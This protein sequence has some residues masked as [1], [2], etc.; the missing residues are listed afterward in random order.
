MPQTRISSR[1]HRRLR[2]LAE[3]TGETSEQILDRALDLLERRRILDGIN[4]GYAA[5]RADADKWAAEQRER[6][7]WDTTLS[8][9]E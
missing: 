2:T 7:P 3:E 5:L 6:A 1:A 9:G 8:D 4:A